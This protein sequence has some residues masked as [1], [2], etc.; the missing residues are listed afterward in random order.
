VV[1]GLKKPVAMGDP[2]IDPDVTG[3]RPMF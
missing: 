3:I 2:P 1:L